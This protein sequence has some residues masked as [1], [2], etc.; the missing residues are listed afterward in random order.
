MP[1]KSVRQNILIIFN[2]LFLSLIPL[3]ETFYPMQIFEHIEFYYCFCQIVKSPVDVDNQ[4]GD[5]RKFFFIEILELANDE[6]R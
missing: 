3:T 6:I 2:I 5:E 4:M 1:Y